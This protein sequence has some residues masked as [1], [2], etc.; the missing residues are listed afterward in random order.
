M[1]QSIVLPT[2][3]F[4]YLLTVVNTNILAMQGTGNEMSAVATTTAPVSFSHVPPDCWWG[5]FSQCRITVLMRVCKELLEMYRYKNYSTILM[6]DRAMIAAHPIHCCRVYYRLMQDNNIEGMR[7]LLKI[8]HQ[9]E[10]NMQWFYS[11]RIPVL[12]PEMQELIEKH[13]TK[14]FEISGSTPVKYNE[15][16]DIILH[17]D[18]ERMKQYLK[19]KDEQEIVLVSHGN[20]ESIARYASLAMLE[21]LKPILKKKWCNPYEDEEEWVAEN[22]VLLKAALKHNGWRV[23]IVEYL[24]ENGADLEYEEGVKTILAGVIT[25]AHEK[26]DYSLLDLCARAGFDFNA[27]YENDGRMILQDFSRA[28]WVSALEWAVLKHDKNLVLWLLAHRASPDNVILELAK[29]WGNQEVLS[30]IQSSGIRKRASREVSM[31]KI[32]S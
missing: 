1:K 29:K 23:D 13:V 5:I 7:A 30:V 6:H 18:I 15:F 19:E 22:R 16:A 32:Q 27:D 17:N 31:E 2:L 21:V 3:A 4:L 28:K 14:Q 12:S 25:L 10:E 20:V 26:D 24:I 9:A 11:N 8:D